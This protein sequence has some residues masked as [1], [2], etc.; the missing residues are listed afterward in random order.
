M[1]SLN[2][3]PPE[4]KKNINLAR[5]YLMLKKVII[6]LLIITS[7]S[8][9]TLLATKLTLQNQFV[10]YINETTL[11]TKYVQLFNN[12]IRKFNQDL[13]NVENVQNEYLPQS[14]F[15]LNLIELM[16]AGINLESININD[17]K[18]LL[19]G[20]ALDRE[21]L[22]ELEKNLK[23]SSLFSDIMIPLENKLIKNDIKFN[24]KAT[25]DFNQLKKNE[26]PK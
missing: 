19:A 25:V 9:I 13:K 7:L 10:K 22:L 4:K 15:Y 14:L 5:A 2:L 12:E 8:S 6:M 1:I 17:N 20:T 11:T 23:N 16:P 21:S 26:S 3:L 24:V 18:M